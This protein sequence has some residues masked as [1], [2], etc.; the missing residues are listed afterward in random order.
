M[1]PDQ[2]SEPTRMKC[3]GWKGQLT[4]DIKAHWEPVAYKMR[5]VVVK[6]FRYIRMHLKTAL[7]SRVSD[8][9]ILSDAIKNLLFPDLE[10]AW[11]EA[12]AVIKS[13][14][15][16]SK[17]FKQN[18]TA[19]FKQAKNEN[20]DEI[21]NVLNQ[22][23]E[24]FGFV[25]FAPPLDAWSV[26]GEMRIN[27][28]E[29]DQDAEHLCKTVNHWAYEQ[30]DPLALVV[31]WEILL[32]SASNAGAVAYF[33]GSSFRKLLSRIFLDVAFPG[34]STGNRKDN[35][36]RK[37]F[38]NAWKA[39]IHLARHYLRYIETKAINKTDDQ[40]VLTAWWMAK[41]A[42]E[43]ILESMEARGDDERATLLEKHIIPNWI[44]EPTFTTHLLHSM[45][46][47]PKTVQSANRY[48]TFVAGHH[49]PAAMLAFI[50]PIDENSSALGYAGMSMT[51]E[52]R[53][54]MIKLLEPPADFAL[55]HLPEEQHAI[56]VFLWNRALNQSVPSFLH[57]YYKDNIELIGNK[58]MQ[59]LQGAEIIARSD[60]PE[61]VIKELTKNTA[62]SLVL[63]ALFA[64]NIVGLKLA[65]E[66]MLTP[67]MKIML[68]KPQIIRD[69]V[70]L[71]ESFGPLLTI[72]LVEM[73]PFLYVRE[74]V[75]IARELDWDLLSKCAASIIERVIVAT[76]L[77]MRND[78]F[79]K[80]VEIGRKNKRF[81]IELRTMRENL[82]DY[83]SKVP[84]SYRERVRY[85][86]R[87]LE[88][89]PETSYRQELQ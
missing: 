15:Q 45:F 83:L 21:E 46:Y 3:E 86:L 56:A 27:A 44:N 11:A 14:E 30:D 57:A 31:A 33:K 25:A 87:E 38:N 84:T 53:D 12:P 19:A 78:I 7:I 36:K 35:A 42:M 55:A 6:D 67:T 76:L 60:Y 72:P 39:R 64:F 2:L 59:L 34:Y 66:G 16:N 73:L 48:C 50:A 85:V 10:T 8:N 23:M 29:S 13:T 5:Q 77:S 18:I 32:G 82:G 61:E 1:A 63:P 52:M 65:T 88:A 40:Q 70:A 4:S 37:F 49:L 68:E 17:E 54:G 58:K 51:D 28:V 81:N 20:S 69:L 71:D 62:K 41:K 26:L 80:L 43:A 79:N 89:I 75:N 74:E 47:M 22:Y 9:E 24:Q